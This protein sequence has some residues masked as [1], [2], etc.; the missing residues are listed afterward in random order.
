MQFTVKC[1]HCGARLKGVKSLMGTVVECGNC[2]KE[3]RVPTF[4]LPGSAPKSKTK[5]RSTTSDTR[6]NTL[7]ERFREVLGEPRSPWLIP[8]VAMAGAVFTIGCLIWW[9]GSADS[10]SPD[11][12]QVTLAELI[13]DQDATT[14]PPTSDESDSD[15]NSNTAKADSPEDSTREI[16][17]SS[18]SAAKEEPV[19]AVAT[20]DDKPPVSR[21]AGEM[22]EFLKSATV[23]IKVSTTK[24]IQSGSGFLVQREGNNGFIVSNSHVIEP[25]EGTLKSIECVFRSGRPD[26]YKVLA[27]VAGRDESRDLAILKV[28]HEKL[29]E[30][31]E[32]SS[33][34]EV[35]ETLSVLVLGFPFGEVLTTS[36]RNPAITVTRCA[37]SSMRRDDY[38]NVSL[39]QVDGGINPGNSGGPV[40]TEDGNLVGV[41]VA[42][43]IGTEIGFAIPRK[44]LGSALAGRISAIEVKEITKDSKKRIYNARPTVIDPRQNI[45]S[46]EMLTFS[47]SEMTDRK[48]EADGS[49]KQVA[50]KPASTLLDVDNGSLVVVP[51]ELNAWAWQVKWTLND[52][53]AKY[54]E[55]IKYGSKAA[56][57]MAS[58]GTQQPRPSKPDRPDPVRPSPESKSA[59]QDHSESS[60]TDNI[61][62][63]R[64][65]SLMADFAINPTTG[66]IA[67][68]DPTAHRARLFRALE[69]F[70][71][72]GEDVRLGDTPV[73]ITY[74]RFGEQE[75]YAA[76]C[77]QDS[78]LYLIDADKFVLLKKIPLASAGVSNVTCSSNPEDPFIYYNFGSGH[79][80]SAGVVDLRQMVDRGLAFGD[81]MDCAISADGKIAYRRGP[82]SP[83]GFASLAMTN[84]FTDE[85]PVFAQLFYDHRSSGGYV[86]DPSGAFTLS[87]NG[88][89]SKNLDKLVATLGFVPASFFR[90]RPL[91]VGSNGKRLYIA[92]YNTLSS[93]GSSI[94]IPAVLQGEA[95]S[96]PR[97]VR[98][99]SDFKRVG[100]KVRIL[101]DDQYSRIIYAFRDKLA[102][103]PLADFELPDEPFMALN[104]VSTDLVVGKKS[105][106]Q[107]RPRDD[108]VAVVAGDLPD[109]ATKTEGGFDWTPT[110][111]QVGTIKVPVTLSFGEIQRVLDVQLNVAQSFVRAPFLI[112]GTFVDDRAERAICWTGPG[113]DAHGR[114]SRSG[115]QIA[116]QEHRIAVIS[117]GAKRDFKEKQL[118]YPVKKAIFADP[119]FAVLPAAENARV[120]V[121]DATTFER[122]KTLLSTEPLNDISSSDGELML[123]GQTVIDVYDIET[124][125]RVRTVGSRTDRASSV[126]TVGLKD[127]LLVNGI[128]YDSNGDKPSLLL[129]PGSFLTIKGGEPQLYSGSFLRRK[130]AETT[131][132]GS[133]QRKNQIRPTIVA[134]PVAVVGRGVSLSLEESRNSV[135][136]PGSSRSSLTQFRVTVIVHDADGTLH[137]RVP[138]LNETVP[139]LPGQ[140]SRPSKLLVANDVAI[141][142]VGDRIFRW[143]VAGVKK[144]ENKRTE[145]VECHVQPRQS[146]FLVEGSTTELKHSVKGGRDPYEFFLLTRLKGVAMDDKTGIITVT[147]EEL[148]EEAVTTIKKA[149]VG[150]SDVGAAVQKLKSQSLDVMKPAVVL[151]G[152][153]INGLPMAVPIHFK[154]IDDD[155]N[156]A[157]MQYFVLLEIPFR[158]L[159]EML[160]E[161]RDESD[162]D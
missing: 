16:D 154:V 29:P 111:S 28:A 134:G 144:S 117:L 20:V 96:L 108:R 146:T 160:R 99:S 157:E 17:T 8:G 158:S 138:I 15:A 56:K 139:A 58:G 128:L 137:L 13:A 124:F 12:T 143:P 102:L 78:H 51:V 60:V 21:N 140:G 123:H 24:G 64:L 136:P 89:Y 114:P 97:G 155:G 1:P 118:T 119:H 147:R 69:G 19:V 132:N 62:I 73:S 145:I 115:S 61:E 38:D 107:I 113:F 32:E 127:G 141:V 85:K 105:S 129:A 75:M 92:S 142:V 52:G 39:L 151:L 65:P 30:P 2:V 4:E 34:V 112:A 3:F 90:T 72:D 23:F 98:S 126:A 33:D 11:E 22:L 100:L 54:T 130:P 74:K 109:G 47:A 67:A 7:G 76:V 43:L 101:P 88:V 26:E 45:A 36:K 42:K 6:S 31:I 152:R 79:G 70:N 80:S 106:V 148:M 159:T 49:W 18:E 104:P 40:V 81:S 59:P 25:L 86:P 153:K 35:H 37:I 161:T 53:T 135:R 55:P 9:I 84:D 50:K 44:H 27:T 131:S 93:L 95:S 94:E 87:G 116:S 150:A 120:D 156:V 133:R 68:V 63:I 103:I 57:E 48:P 162:N 66:D 14:E 125:Q 10:T 149:V 71:G 77:T 83:S 46:I 110:D 41:A 5:E 91:I 82:W 122:V 121:F